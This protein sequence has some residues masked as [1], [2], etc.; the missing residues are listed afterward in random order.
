MWSATAASRDALAPTGS[1]GQLSKR[2]SEAF[3]VFISAE[4]TAEAGQTSLRGFLFLH[5]TLA[6]S[7][8]LSLFATHLAIALTL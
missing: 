8:H 6:S 5:L 4:T 7:L 2:H 1:S 3:E